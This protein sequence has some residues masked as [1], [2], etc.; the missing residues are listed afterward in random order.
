MN[1]EY[2][3]L[4]GECIIEDETGHKRLI[5]YTDKTDEILI[6]ENLIETLENDLFK[7]RS[8]Y[9]KEK[10]RE[11]SI[12]SSKWFNLV[13]L[14]S[15]ILAFQGAFRILLG[16]EASE[17]MMEMHPLLTPFVKGIAVFFS[18]TFGGSAF[19]TT[20]I[21]GITNKEQIRGLESKKEALEKTLE[22][23]KQ[24]LEELNREKQKQESSEKFFTKEVDDLE[25]L[26]DMRNYIELYYDCGVN[27]KKYE[28]YY[29]E[30]TLEKKLSKRYTPAGIKLIKEWLDQKFISEKLQEEFEDREESITR[31]LNK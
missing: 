30:G 11:K 19:L 21:D 3:Y 8:K 12:K 15:P 29:K 22:A 5:E 13:M 4:N 9:K 31:K 14:V 24:H 17:V 23:E 25:T 18:I 6:Q 28:K 2:T 26:N 1:K 27:R 7:A 10:N 20:F 16:P